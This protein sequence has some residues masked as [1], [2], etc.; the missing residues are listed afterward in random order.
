MEDRTQNAHPE[1]MA[2]T[3]DH[4]TPVVL[5]PIRWSVAGQIGDACAHL[6]GGSVEEARAAAE[7]ALHQA[8]SLGVEPLVPVAQCV[9]GLIRAE[10]GQSSGSTTATPAPSDSVVEVHQQRGGCKPRR[11]GRRPRWG[12]DSLTE[13]EHRV[14]TTVAEGFTNS[15]AASRLFLS[16]HTV[17]FH[18]R[19]IYRKLDI[20]SRVQLTRLVLERSAEH[21]GE[22][23]LSGPESR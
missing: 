19:Q 7:T 20:T 16:R 11:R 17:D 21:A 12:W 6:A 1:R 18:L 10:N 13:A 4:P 14:A 5:R 3:A 2:M 23:A 8:E 15:Q 9:L 22:G